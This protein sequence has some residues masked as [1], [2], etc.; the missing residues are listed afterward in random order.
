M[1]ETPTFYSRGI[2]TIKFPFDYLSSFK[3]IFMTPINII[4]CDNHSLFS[5][6]LKNDLVKH[7]IF[8]ISEP[9]NGAQLISIL[10]N[11]SP[12]LILLDIDMPILDG[13]QTLDTIQRLYPR[14]KVIMFSQYDGTTYKEEFIR[15]GAKAFITKNTPYEELVTTIKG[16]AAGTYQYRFVEGY[17]TGIKLT[18]RE[19]EIC[20][21]IGEEQGNKQIAELICVSEKTVEKHKTSLYRKTKSNNLPGLLKAIITKG[22]NYLHTK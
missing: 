12:D 19:K 14:I 13:G 7:N 16:V 11:I 5:T 2:P 8:S 3:T 22:L 9:E 18:P 6:V 21:L 10:E 15:R 4:I 1:G 20:H 17:K